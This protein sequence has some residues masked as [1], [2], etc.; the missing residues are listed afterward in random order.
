MAKKAA[1]K[2]AAPK[3][4]PRPA[5]K[6]ARSSS[7]AAGERNETP[8]AKRGGKV[9]VRAI[10]MGYYGEERKRE[11]DVFDMDADTFERGVNWV[12]EVDPGTR[13]RTTT[14]ADVLKKQHQEVMR[15]RAAMAGAQD[16]GDTV[17]DT[18]GN[19]LGDD[20]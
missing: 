16:G 19:P 3:A 2:K 8:A 14:G 15:E 11:G 9:R 7:P 20:D 1:P 18:G 17:R 12:E 13:K 6:P 4:A 10:K 5:V